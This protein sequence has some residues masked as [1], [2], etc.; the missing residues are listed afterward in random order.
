[1]LRFPI[2]DN[3]EF[4]LEWRLKELDKDLHGR[5]CDTVFALQHILSN[6]QL[7]FPDFT[8]HTEL[9]TLSVINFCNQLIGE[10]IGKLNADEVYSILLGCYFHDA[11]MGIREKDY[12]EFSKQIDFGDYFLTHPKDDVPGIIR[13]FHNEYSGLFV[14]KYAPFFEFPTKAHEFA[15]VEIARGHRKTDLRDPEQYPIALPIPGSKNTIC[16][17]YLAA[18]VRLA[19][20]IDIT[21]ARNSKALYDIN[22]VMAE[23]DLIEFLKHE[24]T[25]SLE[26]RPDE[27]IVGVSTNDE[28]I[29]Q[30][31]E[32]V[33]AKMQKTLDYCRS[34]VHDLTPFH[35][36][37]EKVRLVKV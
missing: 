10:Q 6:Y 31:L 3:Y 23:I 16:L 19:D 9:H 27:F 13:S 7:I 20:E 21:S 12:E 22:K 32:V 33:V 5:F 15:I 1:M 2:M 18:L 35:I 34:V 28:K 14:K 11:G 25:R 8:D 4:A 37:Q 30:G 36:S 24:S 29:F 17:P 26:I